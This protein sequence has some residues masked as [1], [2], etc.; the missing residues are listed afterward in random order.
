M[1]I[2]YNLFR[3]NSFNFAIGKNQQLKEDGQPI[4]VQEY[5]IRFKSVFASAARTLQANV[6]D[7]ESAH[8]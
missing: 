6:D 1:A 7:G 8:R 5:V 2:K 4:K 3:L